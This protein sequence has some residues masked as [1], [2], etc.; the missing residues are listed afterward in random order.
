M[1]GVRGE[2]R[3]RQIEPIGVGEGMNS[4]VF[5]AYDPYLEREI[6]VKEIAKSKL[7]NSFDDYCAEARSMFVVAHPN[8]VG[9]EF[10][11]ETPDLISIALPYFAN[12]SLKRKIQH[13]PL[14]L[15]KFLKTAQ[16]I[17]VGLQR[18]H[19]GNFL[20]LDLKPSNIL[21]D[22]TEKPLI[23]DF[24]QSR[25]MSPG[26]TVAY[27]AGYRWVM[28]PEV[29]SS[30]VATVESDI[31]QVGVLL[32]RAANG[33]VPYSAQKTAITS[34]DELRRQV[35]RGRFPDPKLFLPHV[36]PG[37]RRIIRKAMRVEP[38][39]RYRSASDFAAALGRV[40]LQLD[41]TTTSLGKG[42]YN[43]RTDRV[44]K[45][46]LEVELSES[47]SSTWQ[48]RV[49]T[50]NGAGRRRRNVADYWVDRLG[51]EA[52]WRHLTEVFVDLGQQG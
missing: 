7:G 42:A 39:E 1:F 25:Q 40:R 10:V 28:P 22:D 49:W 24:G 16:G 18:I 23:A 17:L 41:W 9:V 19:S 48:T 13:N 11:C 47:A 37:V 35:L 51:Y 43:W 15:R 33:D 50:T 8:I 6:A 3:Y 21:L 27:P 26:G 36:P 20:H 52:A 29:W 12:G 14:N 44:D 34:N 30:S 38:S 32:Y 45:R 2:I 5:R 31:Y 46:N 4:H